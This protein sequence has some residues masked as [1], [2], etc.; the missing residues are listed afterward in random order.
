MIRDLASTTSA[1]SQAEVLRSSSPGQDVCTFWRPDAGPW[2]MTL[3]IC[4]ETTRLDLSRETCRRC[5][6]RITDLFLP[7]EVGG[8]NDVPLTRTATEGPGGRPVE[9]LEKLMVIRDL[10]V[11]GSVQCQCFDYGA[12]K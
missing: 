5:L 2:E 3:L 11:S 7:L 12:C 1:M 10:M 8:A 4:D 9:Y 6:R